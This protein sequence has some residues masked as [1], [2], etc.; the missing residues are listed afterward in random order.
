MS[1]ANKLPTTS[2]EPTCMSQR[3]APLPHRYPTRIKT[4]RAAN[5]VQLEQAQINKPSPVTYQCLTDIVNPPSLLKHKELIKS[6]DE[7]TWET[8]MCNERGRLT[9]GHKTVEGRNT[10]F[11]IH[12]NKMP[13][14]KK[15]TCARIV[16]SIRP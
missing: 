2:L 3:N 15:V 11:F 16:C 9:Q 5:I 14:H 10:M 13:R 6:A 4:A 1:N 7:E 12:K 8:G